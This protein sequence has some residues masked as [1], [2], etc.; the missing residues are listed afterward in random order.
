MIKDIVGI[1]TELQALGL[2]YP[3][4]LTQSRIEVPLSGQLQGLAAKS[5]SRSGLR[6]LENDLTCTCIGNSLQR[7]KRLQ[8]CRN[9]PTLRICGLC[10]LIPK[11]VPVIAVPLHLSQRFRQ[12]RSDDIRHGG[13]PVQTCRTDRRA[14]HVGR[15][16][17]QGLPCTQVD[18]KTRLPTFDQACQPTRT[19]PEEQFVWANRQ[20]EDAIGA[21]VMRD[22]IRAECIVLIPVGGI[23]KT[24]RRKQP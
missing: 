10:E 18:N 20:F 11:I 2:C 14:I 7:A 8:I 24:R 1:E 16:N 3:D 9:S 6:I 4:G 22:V 21:E 15:T 17:T 5:T 19:V 13:H 12:E 23:R